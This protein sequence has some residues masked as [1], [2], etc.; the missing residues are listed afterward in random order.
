[1]TVKKCVAFLLFV[2]EIARINAV[3]DRVCGRKNT[4]GG[5]LLVSVPYGS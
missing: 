3:L 5:K 2:N 1:M 4:V